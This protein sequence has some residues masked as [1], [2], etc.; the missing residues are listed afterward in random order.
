MS[1]VPKLTGL[2]RY[3]QGFGMQVERLHKDC[4][5]LPSESL[6]YRF[7]F[8]SVL[9]TR[10]REMPSSILNSRTGIMKRIKA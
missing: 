10:H 2:D 8:A 5:R 1:T 9:A 3:V 6:R 4:F 7:V